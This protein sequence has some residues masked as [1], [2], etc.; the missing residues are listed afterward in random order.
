M[1]IRG[2]DR[3]HDDG[4]ND[5]TDG[6]VGE[7]TIEIGTDERRMHV[8]AYNYW[9]SLLKGQD[10]PA[11]EHLDPAGN[12]DFGAHSVLLDFTG[13]IEDPAIR[14]LGRALREECALDQTITRLSEVPA[15][16]LLSR[17]TDHTLQIIANRAP[18]GFEA[19][20]VGTR[21]HA[22][23]YRGIL[24]PFSSNGITIDHIYGVINWKEV[25]GVDQQAQ[26]VAELAAAVR[27][28]PKVAAPATVWADGPSAA[29]DQ[30][31]SEG[32]LA[33][34]LAFAR[35]TAAASDAA[36][37]RSRAALYRALGEAHDLAIVAAADRPALDALL[38]DAGIALTRGGSM[39]APL[40]R[41]VFG[42]ESD[43]DKVT[44]LAAVLAAGAA[45][46][47]PSGGL[48]SFLE[49]HPGGIKAVVAAARAARRKPSTAIG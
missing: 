30:G 37:R 28:A 38:A 43:K 11:V 24:M 26:L 32:A 16:S 18:I 36:E 40:V 6:G 35:G 22:M 3:A 2:F 25:V 34:R 44:E 27:S 47:V 17:L 20:F 15:R 5:P 29:N 33:D 12:A 45:A 31:V 10:F 42:P 23:M 7:A 46:G 21:G 13:G 49:T 9:V 39:M 4:G 19:E 1:D 41:L 14:F 8:R 48:P